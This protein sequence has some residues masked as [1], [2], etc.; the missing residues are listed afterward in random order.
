M[1][2]A[3]VLADDGQIEEAR[4]E[5][6]QAARPATDQE[7]LSPEENLARAQAKV[8]FLKKGRSG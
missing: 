7:R 3:R 2:T 8:T 6:K 5:L 4:E 1:L